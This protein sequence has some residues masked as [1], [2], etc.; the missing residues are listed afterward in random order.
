MSLL[1]R[2]S[3]ALSLASEN[4]LNHFADRETEKREFETLE[5]LAEYL[6]EQINQYVPLGYGVCYPSFLRIRRVSRRWVQEF[7]ATYQIPTEDFINSEKSFP[8]YMRVYLP[9]KE[10]DFQI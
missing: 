4:V 5:Q 6:K 10:I 3:G 1:F 2:K 9:K 7:F 8:A